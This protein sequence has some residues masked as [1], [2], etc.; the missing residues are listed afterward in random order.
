[1]LR[2]YIIFSLIND[3]SGVWNQ[4]CKFYITTKGVYRCSKYHLIHNTYM[5]D[6][7]LGNTTGFSNGFPNAKCK[8]SPSRRCS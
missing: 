8:G 5:Q 1:M 6:H 7:L 3:S 4:I 2:Y